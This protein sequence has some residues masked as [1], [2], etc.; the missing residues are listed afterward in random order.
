MNKSYL[1]KEIRDLSKN[2]DSETQSKIL[3]EVADNHFNTIKLKSLYD[4]LMEDVY[5][6]GGIKGY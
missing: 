5:G 3:D 4:E 2:F 6:D 1:L